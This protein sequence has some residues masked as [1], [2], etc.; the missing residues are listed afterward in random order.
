MFVPTRR[1]QEAPLS[2]TVISG[3]H[4]HERRIQLSLKLLCLSVAIS[5]YNPRHHSPQSLF[6]ME[7]HEVT[8]KVF[9]LFSAVPHLRRERKR[10]KIFMNYVAGC[11]K[12]KEPLE[13][14]FHW[15]RAWEFIKVFKRKSL[16]FKEFVEFKSCFCLNQ[17]YFF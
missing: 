9:P 4:N 15:I 1:A 14:Y 10:D 13:K 6:V 8:V 11:G 7:K 3:K 16:S 17:D 12:W 2:K 5:L